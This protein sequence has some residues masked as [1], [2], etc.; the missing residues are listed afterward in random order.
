[1]TSEA[2]AAP[3]VEQLRATAA[4]K[5]TAVEAAK[6]KMEAARVDP[7][8]N[9]D[10]LLGAAG[11]VKA[12]QDA[13]N[14]ATAAVDKAEFESKAGLRTDAVA[15]VE[16]LLRNARISE[17]L[18][19]AREAGVKGISVTFNEDGTYSVTGNAPKVSG[20]TTGGTGVRR[21]SITWHYNGTDYTSRELIVAFHED[22]EKVLE[23]AAAGAGFDA[24]VKTLAKK[25]GA[26]GTYK[27]GREVDLG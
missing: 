27:D 19:A 1:M 20:G 23:K 17:A 10:A 26:T 2:V 6:A 11:E 9:L 21:G 5:A 25:L 8:A 18:V 24:P 16:E 13:L 15:K 12:A 4:E 22:S 14:R 7:E 3:T